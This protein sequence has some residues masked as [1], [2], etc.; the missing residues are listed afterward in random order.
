MSGKQESVDDGQG[1]TDPNVFS[2]RNVLEQPDA[3]V[4]TML[5]LNSEPC[6]L[7]R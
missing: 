1:N 4:Y 3:R 7:C 2:I 6:V 5:E